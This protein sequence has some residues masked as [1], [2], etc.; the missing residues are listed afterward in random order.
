MSSLRKVGVYDYKDQIEALMKDYSAS[1]SKG[2][3]DRAKEIKAEMDRLSRY[4]TA[5]N[6][7]DLDIEAAHEKLDILRKRHE[8]MKI[9]IESDL[10]SKFILDSAAE[11]D[12]KSYPIRWLIV[13]V[14]TISA[15]IFGVFVILVLNYWRSIKAQGK[16]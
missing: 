16:I 5:F 9:D 14:S 3:P 12:K 13:A 15:L 4:G 7:L 8:L 11:A 6:K 10:P 2:H 1:I